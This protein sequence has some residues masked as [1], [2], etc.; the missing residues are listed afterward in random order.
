MSDMP[1]SIL[2]IIHS[3]DKARSRLLVPP[4]RNGFRRELSVEEFPLGCYRWRIQIVDKA[5][6]LDQAKP[7]TTRE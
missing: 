3:N 4:E 1:D 2:T 5:V 7:P 6:S